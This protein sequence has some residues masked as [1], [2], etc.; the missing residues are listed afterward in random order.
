MSHNVQLPVVGDGMIPDVLT[1][2]G[3]IIMF[4]GGCDTE[5]ATTVVGGTVVTV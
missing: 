3:G 5:A 1:T 4:R 2:G